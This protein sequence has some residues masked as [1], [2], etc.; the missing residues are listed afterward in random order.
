MYE[1]HVFAVSVYMSNC[2]YLPIK[3]KEKLGENVILIKEVGSEGNLSQ[4]SS[5]SEDAM[6]K[7]K[8]TFH[9]CGVGGGGQTVSLTCATIFSCLFF[10][11]PTCY[12][13]LWLCLLWM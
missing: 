4:L 12:C 13:L 10:I 1:W 7:Q 6:Q 5:C 3:K 2:Q 8:Q 9:I 11:S